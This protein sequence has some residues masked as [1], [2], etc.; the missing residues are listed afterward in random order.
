VPDVIEVIAKF[1]DEAAR[2]LEIFGTNLEKVAKMGIEPIAKISP[3]AGAALEGFVA[4]LGPTGLAVTAIGGA[5][6]GAVAGLTALVK[7][8]ADTADEMRDL[9]QITGVSTEALSGLGLAAEKSGSSLEGVAGSFKFMQKAIADATDSSTEANKALVAL[10]VSAEELR[11]LSPEAQFETLAKAIMQVE[12]PARRMQLGIQVFGKSFAE[13]IP[14]MKTVAEEGIE[15]LTQ[16]AR[17]LGIVIE[18]QTAEQADQFNDALTELAAVGKGL[19][20][21][22]GS[23][24]LPLFVDVAKTILEAAVAVTKFLRETGL[25]TG[26]AQLIR[27]QLAPVVEIV[28]ALST[29]FISVSQALRGD[30]SGALETLKTGAMRFGDAFVDAFQ[31]GQTASA[32]AATHMVAH[33]KQVGEAITATSEKAQSAFAQIAEGARSAAQARAMAEAEAK[34]D[35]AQ[36]IQLEL[37]QK[38]AAIKAEEQKRLESLRFLGISEEQAAQQRVVI[39]QTS[40]DAITAANQKAVTDWLALEKQH[41]EAVRAVE[42]DIRT[43]REETANALAQI[44]AEMVGNRMRVLDLEHQATLEAIQRQREARLAAANALVGDVELAARQRVAAEEDA[45]NQ[46]AVAE[47][48]L[49]QQ[50]QAIVRS[51]S[52]EL[53]GIIR[54]LGQSYAEELKPLQ[55][56]GISENLQRQLS[57]LQAAYQ[58]GLLSI[59]AYVEATTLVQRQAD[60]AATAIQY[61]LTPA[62]DQTAQAM[63]SANEATASFPVAL[64]ASA[65]ALDSVAAS[66]NVASASLQQYA[67]S[68]A[69]AST[70]AITPAGEMDLQQRT[71]AAL[72]GQ[73]APKPFK[74]QPPGTKVYIPPGEFH[75]P[76]D[77]RGSMF[78]LP[79]QFRMGAGY[80]RG[81]GEHVN[82]GLQAMYGGAPLPMMGL[83]GGMGYGWYQFPGGGTVPGPMGQR[84]VAILEAGEQVVPIGA[85]GGGGGGNVVINLNFA[86]GVS[87][88]SDRRMDELAR[89]IWTRIQD[90][91]R[92]RLT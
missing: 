72:A 71:E 29:A 47:S 77:I 21:Q 11:T 45:L 48:Q 87:V 63:V 67:A 26:I 4:K 50:R 82:L 38:V 92:R 40:L 18:S 28:R 91:Q 22:L 41:Q 65:V 90:A 68:A 55:L 3:T 75:I 14:V 62:I 5:A 32:E 69:T 24:L 39:Q 17:D 46:I 31:G 16:R 86:Q 51:S 12:D 33:Q 10:G 8:V 66:A 70:T 44:D 76:G 9:S 27:I 60:E 81:A 83:M 2:G 84:S 36:I 58:S 23:A 52:A 15:P 85:T 19:A 73:M 59:N 43:S 54:Q 61:N 79:G 34:G 37:A 57:M 56:M 88:D 13:L 80:M 7:S 6:I 1:R 20:I 49:A 78:N 89:A 74:A 64:S 25:I 42:A 53:L 35:R 30:W